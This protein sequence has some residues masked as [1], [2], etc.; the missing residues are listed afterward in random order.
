MLQ[1][2]SNLMQ[3]IGFPLALIALYLGHRQAQKSRGLEVSLALM[4]AFYIRWEG[5]GRAAITAVEASSDHR[6]DEDSDLRAELIG[7]LNWIDWL[8]RLIKARAVPRPDAML[9]S[10][11]YQITR[12]LEAGSEIKS[13]GT[14]KY[15]Q[16]Y[17]SGLSVIEE[18]LKRSPRSRMVTGPTD[19]AKNI[20]LKSGN[21]PD[22][23]I[24]QAPID[25]ANA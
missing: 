1:T 13:R 19:A 7:L 17:W 20:E 22:K 2:T 14:A 21:L 23:D 5:G 25:E 18:T 8:G 3:T 24:S 10:L 11:Q 16:D 4:E 15:G 9:D 6:A 12:I